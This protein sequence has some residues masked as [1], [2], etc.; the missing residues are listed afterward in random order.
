MTSQLVTLQG[1]CVT[2]SQGFNP[3]EALFHRLV[4]CSATGNQDG[5]GLSVE[6]PPR[7]AL[8]GIDFTVSA[9]DRIGI[10]GP[11]SSGKSTLCRVLADV[12]P[13]SSGVVSRYGTKSI[14]TDIGVGFDRMYTGRET[15]YLQS[16]LLGLSRRART[17]FCEN[18]LV[19][20]GLGKEVDQPISRLSAANKGRLALSCA[21]HQQADLILIDD[22]F[23]IVDPEF[24]SRVVHFLKT[25][26]GQDT[27]LVVI[28]RTKPLLKH[29]CETFYVMNRGK[30]IDS[31]SHEIL[32][33]FSENLLNT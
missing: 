26:R 14:A 30:I 24:T 10:V 2:Y 33:R 28:S 18:A 21:L 31:G 22:V 17:R 32:E 9:G 15:V 23:E 8:D 19:F 27:A 16:L 12:V 25:Q 20:A 29:L 6:S 5:P 13:V 1:V 3:V 4:R 7:S 11:N